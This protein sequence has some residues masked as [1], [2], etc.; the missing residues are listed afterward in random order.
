M[1]KKIVQIFKVVSK[2]LRYKIFFLQFI[3]FLN[4]IAQ[5][6]SILSLAP[7]VAILSNS[8]LDTFQ[9]F[10]PLLN[11]INYDQNKNNLT[12]VF[13]IFVLIIFTVSNIFSVITNAAQHRI[14][15]QFE[16]EL[17]KKIVE[18]FFYQRQVAGIVRNSFYFKS[19]VDKEVPNVISHVIIP[20]MDFNSKIVPLVIILATIFYISPHTSVIIFLFL[21]IGYTFAYLVIKKK[22][23]KNSI[24][25]SKYLSENTVISDDLFK[26]FKESKIFNF[27][28]FL[29]DSF[30]I[31][32]KKITKIIGTNLILY[33]SPKYFFE[34]IVIFVLVTTIVIFSL[35]SEF[36]NALP[37]IS[38]YVVAAYRIMPSLQ[39]ILFAVSSIKGANESLSKLHCALFL[40][41]NFFNSKISKKVNIK[42]LTMSNINFKYKDN[43]IFKNCNIEFNKNTITGLSGESGS[44]KSTL[45]DLLIGFKKIYTG[46][47]SVNGIQIS[48]N[49][50]RIYQ[51]VSIVP[52]NI[53][54]LNDN[55]IKNI[56]FRQYLNHADYKKLLHILKILKLKNL[57]NGN[58]IINKNIKEFGKNFSGGQIQRIGLARALFKDSEIIILDEFTSALDRDTERFI[59]K[60]IK[61]FFKNKIIIIISHSNNTLKKCDTLFS[62]LNHKIIKIYPK[63]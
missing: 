33:T 43:I 19:L 39:S 21:S 62:I 7:L 45:V 25:I 52:Q 3:I 23:K 14:S 60:N 36:N 56:T 42:K 22:L 31:F 44:G 20:L 41:S 32:K 8:S 27:E 2:D 5:L 51:N 58:K 9:A 54:L 24:L 49:N 35:D 63:K 11:L 26:S 47:I 10:K 53:F 38:I 57:Y 50:N 17:S 34:I 28:N 16:L 12:I 29:I 48:R 18:N 6:I 13:S 1:V 55:L 59:F 46:S 40:K 4:S 30:V 15:L 61:T 37:V